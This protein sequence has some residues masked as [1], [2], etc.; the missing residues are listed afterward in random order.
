MW[1][2]KWLSCSGWSRSSQSD[3]SPCEDFAQPGEVEFGR[4][5]AGVKV[6]FTRA[7][8]QAIEH[9]DEDFSGHAAGVAQAIDSVGHIDAPGEDLRCGM[10]AQSLENPGEERWRARFADEAGE[11]KAVFMSD[12]QSESEDSRM[13]MQVR[14]AI[15]VSRRQ[16]EGA[17]TLELR[18]DFRRQRR[19]HFPIEEITQPGSRGR[20]SA[21]R[22]VQAD[23]ELRIAPCHLDGFGG[24]RFLHHEAGLRDQAGAMQA[25]DGGIHRGAAAEVV[26]GH[27]Q[28]LHEESGMSNE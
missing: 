24:V 5:G 4:L 15:P 2:S 14:M 3:L 13:Q 9:S 22:E 16:T 21:K 11:A 8:L 25:F 1:R 10:R 26:G 27:D 17:E 18:A 6:D 23:A 12:G 7:S 19:L 20:I 28:V